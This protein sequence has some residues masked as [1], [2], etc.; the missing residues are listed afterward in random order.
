MEVMTGLIAAAVLAALSSAA[1]AGQA[2]E[3]SLSTR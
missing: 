2:V 1:Y 3:P